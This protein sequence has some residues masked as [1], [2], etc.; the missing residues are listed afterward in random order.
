MTGEI[1]GE[2]P[3]SR[4]RCARPR[5]TVC[6][7]CDPGTPLP[8]AR[9]RAPRRT[10]AGRHHGCAGA[11][12]RVPLRAVPEA[13]LRLVGGG[14]GALS[15]PGRRHHQ[16][17]AQRAAAHLAVLAPGRHR[18]DRARPVVCRAGLLPAG[19][20]AAVVPRPGALPAGLVVR[21]HLPARPLPLGRRP[22]GALP[23]PGDA[24]DRLG[25]LPL[26]APGRVERRHAADGGLR[27]L[28]TP[29][30]RLPVPPRARGVGAVGLLPRH[31]VRARGRCRHP[32]AGAR[33]SPARAERAVGAVGRPPARR[34]RAGRPR[35]PAG[36][37]AHAARGPGQR[38][39]PL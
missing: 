31:P 32:A 23:Q 4:Q 36:A 20:L 18:L 26:P 12:L 10:A 27:A 28:G 3:T 5:L 1:S 2:R 16:L 29:P 38:A 37:A 25:L 9:H 8:H 22:G 24:V 35:R 11:A 39:L 21:R 17:H 13:V 15:A 7:G 33:R 6:F 30:P 19:A 34:R 14:L